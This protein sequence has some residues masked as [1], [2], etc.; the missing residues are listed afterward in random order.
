MLQCNHYGFQLHF[1]AAA[2]QGQR[3]VLGRR[4]SNPHEGGP[5][6][7]KVDPQSG[8]LLRLPVSLREEFG[9]QFVLH[10]ESTCLTVYGVERTAIDL[11][12]VG[13]RQVLGS[14]TLQNAPDLHVTAPLGE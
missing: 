12:M 13:D 1:G 8:H 5:N 4:R 14:T 3:S 9:A 2:S 10:D 6:P 7:L 11:V